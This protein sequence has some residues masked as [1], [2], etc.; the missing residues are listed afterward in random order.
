MFLYENGHW[1][2]QNAD[3]IG[4]NLAIGGILLWMVKLNQGSNMTAVLLNMYIWQNN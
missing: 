1:Q 3:N 2:N 4:N